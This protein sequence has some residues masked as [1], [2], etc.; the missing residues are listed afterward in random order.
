MDLL[1]YIAGFLTTVAFLPQVVKTIRYRS[2]KDI[3]L[4]MYILLCTGITLWIAYGFWLGALPVIIA[5]GVSLVF[6]GIVLLYKIR[7]G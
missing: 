1:G 7:N 3:S 2:T 4:S 5:N 6:A